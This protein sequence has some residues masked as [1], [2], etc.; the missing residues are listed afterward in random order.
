MLKVSAKT[1]IIGVF[2]YPIEHSLSP[3][4]H[5]AAFSHLGL[6]YC[7]LAFSVRP[8]DLKQAVESIKALNLVGVNVTIPHKE[9]VLPYL[10][11]VS[12][13]ARLIGA[14]N[15]IHNKG[16]KLIGYNTD[17][18]GFLT[19]LKQAGF[20]PK[21]KKVVVIGAGG[22]ARA[23]S[24]ALSQEGVHSLFILN[25]TLEK[26]KSLTKMIKKS[27][28]NGVRPAGSDPIIEALSLRKKE[29]IKAIERADLLVNATSLGMVPKTSQSPLAGF[30]LLPKNLVVYDLVYNPAET[31]LIRLAK[32]SKGKT[33]GG[34][35]MLIQQGAKSFEIF[36]GLKAPLEVM[37]KV[38]RKAM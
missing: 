4:M 24:F 1:K 22:A 5:N 15:T 28:I 2:G 34:L 36:T 31:K 33:I 29:L 19:S 23:V 20:N 12:R 8:E 21:G 6:D 27:I 9:R 3:L 37:R 16:G 7:Y 14:V 18:S 26:A 35:E 11:K 13:Q 25:R 30:G 32:K 17:L 10:D 38:M